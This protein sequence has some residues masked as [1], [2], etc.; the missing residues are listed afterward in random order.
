MDKRNREHGS[1]ERNRPLSRAGSNTIIVQTTQEFTREYPAFSP[2]HGH[3]L[4]NSLHGSGQKHYLQADNRGGNDK[5]L[6]DK[7]MTIK[8]EM[9]ELIYENQTLRSQLS[10]IKGDL[11]TYANG[12]IPSDLTYTNSNPFIFSKA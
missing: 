12:N 10:K 11:I 6:F 2:V 9:N 3:R 7:Y 1:I 8:G 5:K 4:E